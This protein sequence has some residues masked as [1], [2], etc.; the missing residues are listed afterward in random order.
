VIKA[1]KIVK[2]QAILREYE[3]ADRQKREAK[4]P[5]KDGNI[6]VGTMYDCNRKHFERAL[7]AYSERLYVGWNPFKKDGQGCW[8]VWFRPSRK[9][10]VLRYYDELTGVKI[11]T[12]E[13]V[14][15]DF[16]HWVADCDYLS[17]DFIGKLRE[18]DSWENKQLISGH[19]DALQAHEDKL[20]RQEDD[21]IK[22]IVKENKK[23]F[24]D[25]LDYTQSGFDPVQFFYRK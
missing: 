16:E 4:F 6:V 15:N 23:A 20:E 19:D 10:P 17:Y 24:R 21:N 22:Q 11:Y 5:Q 18:M 1:D 9:T 14:P 3:R 13:Y 7:K 12:A 2:N 8:E 25:L